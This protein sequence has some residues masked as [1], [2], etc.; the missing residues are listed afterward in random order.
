MHTLKRVGD[1]IDASYGFKETVEVEIV[2]PTEVAINRSKDYPA[3]FVMP[4]K[5]YDFFSKKL[6][7]YSI[8]WYV[9][10]KSG[11]IKYF[12]HKENEWKAEE[13]WTL[14]QEL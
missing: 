7:S 4:K 5:V 12:D 11:M 13:F 3:K 14:L 9:I 10:Y 1:K 8:S 2:A 6:G